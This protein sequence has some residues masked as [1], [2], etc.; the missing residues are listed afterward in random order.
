MNESDKKRKPPSVDEIEQILGDIVRDGE[1]ASQIRAIQ[2]LRNK[3]T[4]AATLPPP[5]SDAEIIER[6]ARLI[7]AAGSTA[8]RLAYRKAFPQAQRKLTDAAPKVM[9][10]DLPP[11]DKASLPRTLRTLWKMFPEVKPRAGIPKGF[12]VRQGLAVQGEWCQKMALKML[13]DR[14]QSKLDQIAVH[15]SIEEP[16]TAA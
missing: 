14:E 6:L 10:S 7:R 9:E 13:M 8:A 15:A 16:E 11:I 12:P 5:L 4:E 2:L 1:G 3:D